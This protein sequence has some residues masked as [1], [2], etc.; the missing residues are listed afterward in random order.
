MKQEL[1]KNQILY[2]I[3][4]K[5]TQI[6]DLNIAK[7]KGDITEHDYSNAN[8]RLIGA[9]NCLYDI[10]LNNDLLLDKI[11]SD[12]NMW[13]QAKNNLKINF[14]DKEDKNLGLFFM[15]GGAADQLMLL[16]TVP[17][18]PLSACPL[19]VDILLSQSIIKLNSE[20]ESA[21]KS[22]DKKKIS[23]L[24]SDIKITTELYNKNLQVL[25]NEQENSS[26]VC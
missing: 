13:H 9:L 4:E 10:N 3:K 22:K 24:K 16:L 2:F 8:K 19:N 11:L 25:K 14:L 7:E 18:N 21:I 6:Q 12:I 23:E 15:I 5:K 20:L 26:T 17:E 1:L